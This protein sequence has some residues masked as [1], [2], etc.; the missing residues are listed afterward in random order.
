MKIGI[1]TIHKVINFGSALQAYALQKYL[2]SSTNADVELIDYIYPNEYHYSHRPKHSAKA[3]VLSNLKKFKHWIKG[4]KTPR[5][6]RNFYDKFF[7]LSTKT[8]YSP[9]MIKRD[10]PQYD[11]YI[12][13]SDQVWNIN[14]LH[15]DPAMY[16]DFA[17]Y[18]SKIISFGASFSNKSLP[19]EYHILIRDYLNKYSAIGVREKSSLDLLKCIG[20]NNTIP[21]VCNSDPTLLLDAKDYDELARQS[22]IHIEGDYILVYLLDYAYDP[23]PTITQVTEL[24]VEELGCKVVRLLKTHFAYAGNTEVVEYAGPCEFAWLFK[25]AKF[26]ITSSF[27]GTMFSLI[28]RKPFTTIVPGAD[29]QDCRSKDFLK[30][31]GL[32]DRTS[33]TD[34]APVFNVN[35]PFTP[36]VIERVNALVSDSKKYLADAIKQ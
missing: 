5:Y 24:A 1:I 17:P 35:N 29:H 34:A 14:C 15:N 9:E 3:F 4:N 21:Q 6:Y 33:S 7:N 25:H 12:T 18:G 11:L 2:Q 28:Y 13:G 30:L 31:I 22:Q 36:E 16:C 23:E 10:A 8:F 26:V 20:V 19:Q 32:E 27:H